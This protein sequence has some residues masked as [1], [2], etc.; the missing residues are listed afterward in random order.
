M[1]GIPASAHAG[2]LAPALDAVDGEVTDPALF[3]QFD[4][5]LKGQDAASKGLDAD[6]DAGATA[7]AKG[8]VWKRYSWKCSSPAGKK[9]N[10][11]IGHRGP[12]SQT[13][14]FNNHCNQKRSVRTHYKGQAPGG[15]PTKGSYCAMRVN[16]KTKGSKKFTPSNN[17]PWY[18]ATS[19]C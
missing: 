1:A 16:P 9:F 2:D 19:N 5:D 6:A 11:S 18:K 12:L 8:G 10:I 17:F 4:A 3:E 15:E 13:I 14:Y 7:S